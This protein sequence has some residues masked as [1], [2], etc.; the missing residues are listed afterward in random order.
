L[1]VAFAVLDDPRA[2]EGLCE[3]LAGYYGRPFS[4]DDFSQLGKQVLRREREFIKAA[5]FTSADDRLPKFFRTEKLP[6]HNVT[7]DVGD[8][9]LDTVF[10]FAD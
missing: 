9:Q 1:F 2:M 3:M 8:E 5:G 7:F 4:A 10:N 6:P